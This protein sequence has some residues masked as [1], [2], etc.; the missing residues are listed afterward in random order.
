MK[1]NN[2][3]QGMKKRDFA[4]SDVFRHGTGQENKNESNCTVFLKNGAW[5]TL[6]SQGSE[7]RNP[8]ERMVGALSDDE[9]RSWSK[10][11][12]I[13][14]PDYE[15]ELTFSYGIPF[16]V[17][18]SGRVYIFFFSYWNTNMKQYLENPDEKPDPSKRKY[19]EHIS[20]HL[21]FIFSDDN[22]RTWSEKFKINLPK[23]I[24][25]S[26]QG[27][28]HGWVN[29]PPQI[30]DGQVIFTYS[31]SKMDIGKEFKHGMVYQMKPSESNV[32][33][34]ENILTENNPE[35]LSFKL[36]PEGDK[37]IR[38]DVKRFLNRKPL[39]NL[40]DIF[41]GHPEKNSYN[42]EEMT[43]VPLSDGR[44]FGLGRTKLGCPCYTVSE[45]KGFTWSSPEPLR[46]S[47]GG[48]IIK[49]PMTMC[50]IAKTSD[51]H[52]VL[53]FNNNDGSMNGS[54]HV[55]DGFNNRNPLWMVVGW[56]IPAENGNGGLI[57]GKP[58]I[59]AEA[60]KIGKMQQGKG[61]QISMPQFIEVDGN[62][63]LCYNIKKYDILMD[64]IPKEFLDKLSP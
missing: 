55:W 52:F 19:P 26:I 24:I 60:D 35:K 54:R 12:V 51:G 22:C 34:C 39:Q 23:R 21:Y 28:I 40:H 6:W 7:E 11:L 4:Y 41:G 1:T 25:N 38:V 61:D 48:E 43:I 63:Y 29:H 20:G 5:F 53:L 44:W 14:E 13:M 36:L 31:A 59:V 18:D 42:F 2:L 8:D 58:E 62:Y 37:G 27:R 15:N 45:D 46:Y 32:V 49:H 9:G 16:V 64:K 10:P 30:I 47:P 17:P 3:M 57:F 50:P 56:E 33:L